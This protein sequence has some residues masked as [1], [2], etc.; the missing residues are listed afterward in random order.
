MELEPNK[1]PPEH[2]ARLPL[3]DTYLEKNNPEIK[4]QKYDAYAE[5]KT[6]FENGNGV[7]WGYRLLEEIGRAH[8]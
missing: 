6:A 4:L 3:A 2:Q 1:E 5:A 7:A 8:V